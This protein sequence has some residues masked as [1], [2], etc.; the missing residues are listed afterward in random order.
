MDI[1]ARLRHLQ[2]WS[3]VLEVSS[4]CKGVGCCNMGAGGALLRCD[5]G[6][7]IEINMGTT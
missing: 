7:A 1:H 3:A 6:I 4:H 2:Q 5:I